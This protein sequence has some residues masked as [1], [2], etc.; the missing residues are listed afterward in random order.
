[1]T[2]S[3]IIKRIGGVFLVLL[4]VMLLIFIML[5]IIPGDPVSVMLSEHVSQETIDRI[6]ISMGLDRSLPAQFFSYLKGA[7]RGDLGES[8]FLKEPVV[9]LIAEAFPYTLKLAVFAALIAWA[10]GI[11]SGMICAMFNNSFPDYL[12]RG[13]SLFGVSVPIFMVALCLQYLLYFKLSV[14][15]LSYDGSFGS[16]VLPAIAL[17]WNSAGSVARLTRSS[18]M[19]QLGSPYIDTAM[20]KGLSYKGAVIKHAFRNAMLPIVTM[21]ALQFSGMLSGAVITESIFS[22]PGIGK[23]ALTAIQ[24]RDMP[25]LQGTV[26][27]TA[28]L[29]AIGNLLADVLNALLDPRI[30]VS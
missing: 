8:Y 5:R 3:G 22:I 9:D 7:V 16:M 13:L 29:I 27:F 19:E 30:S 1:M 17:G 21:M 26:L 10:F 2:V 18:L 24:T 14:F 25:L 23:L 4:G 15:P 12:F 6:K 20:A 11:I 28:F